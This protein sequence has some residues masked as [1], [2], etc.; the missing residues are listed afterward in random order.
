MSSHLKYYILDSRDG[1]KITYPDD[2]VGNWIDLSEDR[3]GDKYTYPAIYN[4]VSHQ[5]LQPVEG[6][7][8]WGPYTL[9]TETVDQPVTNPGD[10]DPITDPGDTDDVIDSTESYY[11][12]NSVT[13]EIIKYPSEITYPLIELKE[14]DYG[15]KYL[16][17]A[18]YDSRTHVVFQPSE[19]SSTHGDWQLTTSIPAYVR[20]I[21]NPDGISVGI[22]IDAGT[23]ASPELLSITDD[24]FD[25]VNS[26]HVEISSDSISTAKPLKINFANISE[27]GSVDMAAQTV[28]T[29]DA[30]SPSTSI[31]E[32]APIG[33]NMNIEG[34]YFNSSSHNDVITGTQFSDFLRAGAG[35]DE[36]DA[37]DGDDLVRAGAG[38]DSIILGHGKDKL[39]ITVDQVSDDSVDTLLDFDIDED[40]V[41]YESAITCSVESNIATFSVTIDGIER[42]SQLIFSG[43]DSIDSTAISSVSAIDYM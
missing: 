11:L 7:D 32:N 13:N 5:V 21:N 30:D 42:Q 34:V 39:Y 27:K 9:V 2:I 20:P 10:T 24:H 40:S 8:S 6:S 1:S 38:S 35:D 12:Y 19:D 15:D 31:S 17:P 14:A 28:N 37:G 25:E 16:Y 29:S 36:I 4:L 41:C 23:E 18:I 26:R 22:S 43:Y 33:F 3:Y